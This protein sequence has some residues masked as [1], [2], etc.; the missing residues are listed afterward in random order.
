ML[1][2]EVELK[3][4]LK[5]LLSSVCEGRGVITCNQVIVFKDLMSVMAECKILPVNFRK[6]YP[7]EKSRHVFPNLGLNPGLHAPEKK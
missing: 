3:E 6:F 7:S 2:I 5:I 4:E 1:T